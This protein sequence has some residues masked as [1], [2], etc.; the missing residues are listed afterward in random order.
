MIERTFLDYA[1][2]GLEG[3][4]AVIDFSWHKA[5]LKGKY[6]IWMHKGYTYW[7]GIFNRIVFINISKDNAM[8]IGNM[9]TLHCLII[10]QSE[11]NSC[12]FRIEKYYV[13]QFIFRKNHEYK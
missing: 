10:V 6:M 5:F 3:N 4:S 12:W 8:L 11:D 13:W 1:V 7:G 9:N 2:W